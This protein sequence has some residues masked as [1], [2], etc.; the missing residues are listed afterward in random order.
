[1]GTLRED[2]PHPMI[3]R[4]KLLKLTSN[5]FLSSLQIITLKNLKTALVIF[6]LF[7]QVLC[8]PIISSANPGAAEI[9]IADGHDIGSISSNCSELEMTNANV[10]YNIIV[11]NRLFL[12]AFDGNYTIYNP[13]NET[14]KI[15]LTAPFENFDESTCRV[16]VDSLE[17]NFETTKVN[18]DLEEFSLIWVNINLSLNS[19]EAKIVRYNYLSHLRLEDKITYFEI[20]YIVS[21][22]RSWSGEINETVSFNIVGSQPHSYIIYEIGRPWHEVIDG[23]SSFIISDIENGQSY[24]WTW[25]NTRIGVTEDYIQLGFS[26]KTSSISIE[27]IYMIFYVIYNTIRVIIIIVF[28][29]IAKLFLTFIFN[30]IAK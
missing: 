28:L 29:Y 2:L 8:S 25:E 1:M 21:T 22:G 12:I 16:T 23:N 13:T 14:K 10:V 7:S 11:M 24:Q 9:I 17:T 15:V 6:F 27:S 4:Q 5:T 30:K 20:E 3:K 18:I 26:Y 19:G